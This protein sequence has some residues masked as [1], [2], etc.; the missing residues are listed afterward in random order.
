MARNHIPNQKQSLREKWTEMFKRLQ[1]YQ[2][3]QNG[4]CNVPQ[5]YDEDPHLGRWVSKQREKY[6]KGLLA[7]ERYDQLEA[8]GF[9]WTV[10]GQTEWTKMFTRLRA[11]QQEHNGSCNV[12]RGYPQDPALGSWVAK[13]RHVYKK[14]MLTKERLDQLEAI[15]FQLKLKCAPASTQLQ[16]PPLPTVP[17]SNQRLAQEPGRWSWI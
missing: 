15:G 9:Q 13:Q 10:R 17:K 4:S 14:G 16:P 11:Y 3:E 2:Q 1:A 12:P 5:R 6:R 7:K 8:I